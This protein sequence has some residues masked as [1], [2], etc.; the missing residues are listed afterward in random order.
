MMAIGIINIPRFARIV[1]AS[2]MEE[3]EK[4]YVTAARAVGAGNRRIIFNAIF[5]NCLAPIIVQASLGFGAAIL[6][7]AGLSFLAASNAMAAG[8]GGSAGCVC[9]TIT[10][11]ANPA[12]SEGRWGIAGG[13]AG[14]VVRAPS[15]AIAE[16]PAIRRCAYP[17]SAAPR[18]TG[19]VPLPWRA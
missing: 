11:A 13:A 10:P 2:V 12:S 4:D 15:D 6:D 9:S 19:T 7:A 17:G 14:I 5:P 3:Y 1:R 18:A 16:A 8:H